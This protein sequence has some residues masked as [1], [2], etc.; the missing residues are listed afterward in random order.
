LINKHLIELVDP[1][2]PSYLL[3][4]RNKARIIRDTKKFVTQNGESS[5]SMFGKDTLKSELTKE[6]QIWESLL[7][8]ILGLHV[9]QFTKRILKYQDIYGKYVYKEIDFIAEANG[10]LSLC[11]FKFRQHYN[12]KQNKHARRQ[13][14]KSHRIAKEKYQL[15]D[16]L[17]VAVDMSYALGKNYEKEEKGPKI[18]R[19]LNYAR[20]Y[21]LACYKKIHNVKNFLKRLGGPTDLIWVDSEEIIE[22]ALE[23]NLMSKEKL[24]KIKSVY[25]KIQN[26]EERADLCFTTENDGELNNPFR[27]LKNLK[28]PDDR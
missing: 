20:R 21:Y 26:E 4:G 7:R 3:W 17:V 2:N 23:Q 13:V 9:K 22:I 6:Y 16:P 10:S 27:V 25:K 28:F 18:G 11:E 14:E 15:F 1:E 12:S 19:M 5:L 24:S 8:K